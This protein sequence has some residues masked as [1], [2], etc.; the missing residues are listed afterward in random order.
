[1]DAGSPKCLGGSPQTSILIPESAVG[2]DAQTQPNPSPA[3]FS[4][5]RAVPGLPPRMP[6]L[7]IPDAIPP[8]S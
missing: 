7:S 4:I 1:M 5:P 3:W 6:P 8:S 2:E